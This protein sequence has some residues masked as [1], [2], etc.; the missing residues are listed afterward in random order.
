M[1]LGALVGT[2]ATTIFQQWT[3]RKAVASI[4]L[5]PGIIALH[6]LMDRPVKGFGADV[7]CPRFYIGVALVGAAFVLSFRAT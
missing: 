7:L 2:L 1:L 4:I 3:I 5:I 6:P